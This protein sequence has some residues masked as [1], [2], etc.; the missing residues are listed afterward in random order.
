MGSRFAVLQSALAALGKISNSVSVP[1]PEDKGNEKIKK[2]DI[3][4]NNISFEYIEGE[5]VI[6]NLNIDIP[7]SHSMAIV[8]P[9][10]SGKST[11]IRLIT[12][13]YEVKNGE[14][15]IGNTPLKEISRNSIKENIVLVPQ[16]PAIFHNTIRF[17]I[18]LNRPEVTEEQM[19]EICKKIDDC[20]VIKVDSTLGQEIKLAILKKAATMEKLENPDIEYSSTGPGRDEPAKY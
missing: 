1:L 5:P 14:I 8:G 18:T 17:N 7:K 16:D 12:R 11:L 3:K 9:T 19:I 13:Q 20:K 15:L 6:N 4:L 2:H 10:G